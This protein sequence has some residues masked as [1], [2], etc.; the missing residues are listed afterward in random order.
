MGQKRQH[1]VNHHHDVIFKDQDIFVTINGNTLIKIDK[2][3]TTPNKHNSFNTAMPTDL[4][5]WG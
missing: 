4:Q 2:E 3:K 1:N 5:H